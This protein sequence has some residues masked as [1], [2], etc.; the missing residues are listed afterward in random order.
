MVSF[1]GLSWQK[2]MVLRA[3]PEGCENE[4]THEIKNV[5]LRPR[6]RLTC[7]SQAAYKAYK[8]LRAAYKLLIRPPP[9]YKL[10]PNCLQQTP[11]DSKLLTLARQ[12]AGICATFSV[13]TDRIAV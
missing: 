13:H 12:L 2:R 8:P 3:M 6:K 9:A 4:R 1:S 5:K 10:L 11:K 7:P